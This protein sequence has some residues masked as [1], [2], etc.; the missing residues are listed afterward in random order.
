MADE[1]GSL[2]SPRFLRILSSSDHADRSFER[3][4]DKRGE[5]MASK[6][7]YFCWIRVLRLDQIASVQVAPPGTS[8]PL[9]LLGS[10]PPWVARS[11]DRT[12]SEDLDAWYAERNFGKAKS[13]LIFQCGPAYRNRMSALAW[14]QS[15]EGKYWAAEAQNYML[16]NFERE[17]AGSEPGPAPKP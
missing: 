12:I 4:E 2:A 9:E 7:T 16:M 15:R 13:D 6:Q 14:L 3:P 10:R 5:A 11:L 17:P 1:I 8:E